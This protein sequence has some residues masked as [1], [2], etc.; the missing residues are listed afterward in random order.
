MQTRGFLL[1]KLA[2]GAA[3]AAGMLAAQS[4]PHVPGRLLV[5]FKPDVQDS[6]AVASI[7]SLGAAGHAKL[8]GL[9]VHAVTLHPQADEQATLKAFRN[10]PEVAFAEFDEIVQLAGYTPNDPD[11]A[12]NQQ[13]YDQ[14]ISAPGAWAITTG[15]PGVTIAIIDTGVDGTH[16]DLSARVVPGWNFYDNNSNTAD[17][18]GHGTQTAGT[19]AATI[20]NGLGVAGTCGQCMIM[21][22]RVSDTN[23][24]ATYSAIASALVYAAQHGARVANI[25]YQVNTSSTVT[26]AA[27]TFV[28]A[29]GVVASSAGNYSTDVTAAENP[30]ILTVGAI[31]TNNNLYSWSNYGNN[32]DLVAPGCVYTTLNG[33]GYSV[34]CGTSFSSPVV[35]GVAGLVLSAN[36]SLSGSAVASLLKQTADDLGVAGWDITF[37]Y[38]RVDAAA[39]VTAAGG[40]SS[41]GTTPPPPQ[42]P[43]PPPP[44][45]VSI[46]T[47]QSGTTVA[48]TVGVDVSA[49]STVGIASVSMTVDGNSLCTVTSSPFNCTWNT[50]SVANGNHT[51]MATARDTSGNATNASNTVTVS[52]ATPPNVSVVSPSN[53]STV[54]GVVTIQATATDSDAMKSINVNV[55]GNLLCSSTTSPVSCPWSSTGVLNGSHTVS[56]TATDLGGYSATASSSVTVNNSVPDTTPP[57]VMITSPTS[58]ANV[59]LRSFQVAVTASDNVGVVGVD[60]YLDG[61]LYATD[62]KAPY[63]FNVSI[64]HGSPNGVHTVQARARDAAGNYTMS[65]LVSVR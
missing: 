58:G 18:Y 22:I 14:Q 10:R 62:T 32:Q 42:P 26:S 47:P 65:N 44:P 55:D 11:Y 34:G 25:S 36:P 27:Q 60:L 5:G 9:N 13:V 24:G 31:D 45:T 15:S 64:K 16:E 57:S 59:N 12:A 7:Q 61:G 3:L 46:M 21:P 52:N 50:G 29:G 2:L 6:Q 40:G 56:V 49:S 51:L 54:S 19:A 30:Y 39:A 23:G 17:V 41:S 43:P 63:S 33:G 48:S 53:G 35:A 8:N 4:R 20:N 38:G 28:N 37:G 1:L